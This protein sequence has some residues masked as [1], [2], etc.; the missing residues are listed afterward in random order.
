LTS[1][2]LSLLIAGVDFAC[3][4]PAVATGSSGIIAA[5]DGLTSLYSRTALSEAQAETSG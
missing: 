1:A 3:T 4:G 5:A 2:Q